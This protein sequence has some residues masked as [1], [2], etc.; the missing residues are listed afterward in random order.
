M[1]ANQPR[2]LYI[3]NIRLPTEKAHGLQIMQNCEAFAEQGAEVMLWAARRVNTPELRDADAFEYYGVNRVFQ[4]WRLPTLD[5]V[6]LVPGQSGILARLFFGIQSL[7]FIISALIA[8][9]FRGADVVY[10]RDASVLFALLPLSRIKGAKVGY[11]AHT[12][13]NGRFGR[14]MQKQVVKRAATFATTRKLADELIA[15]GA[16]R[17]PVHV[18]HDGIR[19]ARFQ[20]LPARDAA[21][22]EIGWPEVGLIVGYVGRLQT[23]AMDK[24]VGTVIAALAQIPDAYLALVGGPDDAAEAYRR[25]WLELGLPESHFLYTGQVK[26]DRVPI[27]LA[28]FDIGVLPLPFTGHFAYYAS[29]IKLFEYMASGCAVVASD[30]P[31]IREVISDG[32]TG[33]L[34]PPSDIQAFSLVINRLK[35][36]PA[37]RE[38]LAKNAHQLVFEHYTWSARAAA[39]LAVLLA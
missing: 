30:L 38:T 11:E 7:T 32:E 13:A 14:W 8:L 34:A 9:L 24:G 37:L 18:A 10:S 39:I 21:R 6:A 5:L 19:T 27:Y 31:S 12:L 15:L 36:D 3:A 25:Q 29:P 23:L 1:I 20:N 33:L 17:S 35:D 2:L 4:M 26:A 22:R 16:A 28:T